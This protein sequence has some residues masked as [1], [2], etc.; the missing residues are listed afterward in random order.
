MK[1]YKC[2][3]VRSNDSSVTELTNLS[4]SHGKEGWRLISHNAL[5]SETTLGAITEYIHFLTFERGT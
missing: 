2:L 1:E 3:S 4:S 5:A